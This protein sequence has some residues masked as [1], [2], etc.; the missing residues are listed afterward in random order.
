MDYGQQHLTSPPRPRQVA[1][2]QWLYREVRTAGQDRQVWATADDSQQAAYVNGTLQVCKRTEPCAASQQWLMPSGPA[3]TLVYP[4]YPRLTKPPLSQSRAA[5][6]LP[7][8]PE[9][10]GP[11]LAELNSFN[12]GCSDVGGDCNAVNVVANMLTG[13]GN[14][15]FPSATWFYALAAVPGV[16][17]Q[18]VTDA[19]GRQ[20]L[21]FTF[22]ARDGVTAIL[23]NATTF[24]YAGY[25]RDGQ[26][27]LVLDQALVSG[28]GVRP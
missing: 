24:H 15:P 25:V 23:V 7:T 8:L 10:P 22:P 12:T 9:Y 20:D 6:P 27:T 18:D 28:P 4:Q 2:G 16:S 5:K 3:F 21:A 13:Y 26:Q 19:A 17:V 11:L 1:P 14:Y